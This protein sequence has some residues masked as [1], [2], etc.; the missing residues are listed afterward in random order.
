[1]S[2]IISQVEAT[3]PTSAAYLRQ[4]AEGKL[5]VVDSLKV[6][7]TLKENENDN[8]VFVEKMENSPEQK[9]QNTA[10]NHHEKKQKQ[11]HKQK[12]KQSQIPNGSAN[13][14][15]VASQK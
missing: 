5:K 12:K 4:I 7:R 10:M 8:L 11:K 14:A 15:V 9:D 6:S 1:M 3:G 13:E 2:G